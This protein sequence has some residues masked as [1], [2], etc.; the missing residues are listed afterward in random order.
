MVL[1]QFITEHGIPNVK[2]KI[3]N[4]EIWWETLFDSVRN[5]FRSADITIAN[6]KGKQRSHSYLRDHNVLRKGF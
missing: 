1:K 6:S 4:S 5:S 2:R 3:E